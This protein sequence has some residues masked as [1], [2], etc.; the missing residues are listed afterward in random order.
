MVQFTPTNRGMDSQCS[1]VDIAGLRLDVIV[2]INESEQKKLQ[3]VV[4]EATMHVS[5]LVAAGDSNDLNRSINYSAITKRLAF[6]AQHGQWGLIESMAN[7]LCRL[8]L[9]EP[10]CTAAEVRVRKPDALKG[11]AEPSVR[12]RATPGAIEMRNVS[13]GA[14]LDVL[15][16]SAMG[17]AYRLRLEAGSRWPLPKEL[18]AHVMDGNADVIS[19]GGHRSSLKPTDTM[20]RGASIIIQAGSQGAALLVVGQQSIRSWGSQRGDVAGTIN[21]GAPP[22]RTYIALGSNLGNRAHH[23]S[24]ALNSMSK[25]C[26]SLVRVSQLYVTAP[27]HVVDQPDF[28]NAACELHTHLGPAALLSAL[29]GIERDA[30]RKSAGS[31]RYGPRVLD[32]DI[33]IYGEDAFTCET[34]EGSLTVPHALMLQRTF[35]LAP[36]CDIA[37]TVRHPTS[38]QSARTEFQRL[39]AAEQ[40][41]EQGGSDSSWGA[42]QADARLPQRVLPIRADLYWPLGKRTYIM[43]ILN[44]TPDSFSDGGRGFDTDLPLAVQE[45]EAMVRAGADVIDLGAESTRPGAERVTEEEEMRR[46]L[47]VIRAIREAGATSSAHGVQTATG[48]GAGARG[49][50]SSIVLSVDTT[51]ASVAAAAVAAGADI[52]N[53]ISGGT[54]DDQMI[55]TAA[56][57]DVPLVLMHTR[58]TPKT[59]RGMTTYDSGLSE[60]VVGELKACVQKAHLAGLPPWRLVADPGIGFAKTPA[61]SIEL[62]HELPTFLDG[63]VGA[64]RVPGCRGVNIGRCGGDCCASLVGA[65]RKGFIGQVLSQPDPRRRQ[66][67]NAATVSAAIMAGADIVRVHEVNEMRQ[68]ALLADAIHRDAPAARL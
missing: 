68:V 55:R 3:P 23:I 63:T 31:V 39:C 29:K 54:F 60:G 5:T 50:G 62:L 33:L 21:V 46:L 14:T 41:R 10:Q 6:V 13:E 25:L 24:S 48:D 59:M 26:G 38:G 45:A 18:A 58:G 42:A 19:S 57:L 11:A 27:Q 52:I 22:V 65:S 16:E 8:V 64:T 28:L 37:A 36:L 40:G 34:P 67:G 44:L 20:P 9:L 51:R 35:V 12:I 7:A 47:P 43:G 32:L 56:D 1:T 4:L 49:W 15:C 2:G 30:G 61:Q 17:A 66:W 53:D